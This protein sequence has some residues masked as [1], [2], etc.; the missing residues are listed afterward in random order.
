MAFDPYDIVLSKL[1]RNS[2]SDRDDVRYLSR[3]VPLDMAA[4][5]QRYETELRWQL[6]RPDRED[7]TMTLWMEMLSEQEPKMRV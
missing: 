1:E 7:L 5:Q 4:L 6:G 2:Q 3:T